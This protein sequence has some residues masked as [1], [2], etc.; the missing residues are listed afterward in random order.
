[1]RGPIVLLAFRI[2]VVHNLTVAT[3]ARIGGE[4]E[5]EKAKHA[6]GYRTDDLFVN[7]L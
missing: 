4:L 7:I 5:A 6:V 3:S 2:A 1:M